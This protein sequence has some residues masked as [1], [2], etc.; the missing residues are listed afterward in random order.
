MKAWVL[1]QEAKHR[2]MAAV[3]DLDVLA[4]KSDA[5]VIQTAL[6]KARKEVA[7]L[8]EIERYLTLKDI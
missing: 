7:E 8:Q 3:I 6:K 4:Q 1:V 5:T 2:T